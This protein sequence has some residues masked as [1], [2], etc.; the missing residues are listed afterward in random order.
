MASARILLDGGQP[1]AARG[2]H[3]GYDALP[4]PYLVDQIGRCNGRGVQEVAHQA[5]VA[6][7]V[8]G[9]GEVCVV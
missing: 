4:G 6:E 8:L 5:R 1:P 7:E 2:K 3:L 9:V